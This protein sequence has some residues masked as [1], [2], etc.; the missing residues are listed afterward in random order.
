MNQS[1]IAFFITIATYGTWLPGDKRGWIEYQVGWQLPDPIRE[2]EAGARM[3]E[4]ACFL[5]PDDRLIVEQQLQ[6]TCDH[7]AWVLH[8]QNCRSNHMHVLVGC[9]NVRPKKIR[10]DIKAWCT[11]RW[12]KNR[13]LYEKT[14]GPIVEVSGGYL[15]MKVWTW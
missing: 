14:G 6:E 8:A 10:A 15:M 11:R 1:P 3:N 2:L 13:I 4:N 12:K 7:R 9:V 5:T